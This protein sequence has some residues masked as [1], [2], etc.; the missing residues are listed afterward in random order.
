MLP[1][2]PRPGRSVLFLGRY[3]EHFAGSHTVPDLDTHVPQGLATWSRWNG[4]DDLLLIT[5]YA[6]KS[7]D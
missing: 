4:T 6:P 5:A 3:D 2:Y 1:G 7:Q